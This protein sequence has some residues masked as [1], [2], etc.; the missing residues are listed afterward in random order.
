MHGQ[1]QSG[2]ARAASLRGRFQGVLS[3]PGRGEGG[4]VHR[5]AGEGGGGGGEVGV[6]LLP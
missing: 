3:G 6:V 2:A 5:R 1:G 4:V